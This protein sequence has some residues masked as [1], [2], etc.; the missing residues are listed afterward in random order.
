MTQQYVLRINYKWNDPADP[1][2][3]YLCPGNKRAQGGS[4]PKYEHTYVFVNDY[5]AVKEQQAEYVPEEKAGGLSTLSQISRFLLMFQTSLAFYSA[6]RQ[7][8]ENVLFSPFLL[9]ITLPS[10][11]WLLP[12]SYLSYKCG[13][14]STR[15]ISLQNLHWLQYPQL[16]QSPQ[17]AAT[18]LPILQRPLLNTG[19]CKYSKIRVL[20][21]DA[22]ILIPMVKYGLQQARQRSLL[23][24]WNNYRNIGMSTRD[25]IC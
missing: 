15:R 19:G 25:V 14:R 21:W 11:I 22:Q 17:P 18:H 5:S 3:C 16:L 4:N 24:S 13:P 1:F 10:L 23:S 2:K 20:Q 7:W 8:L 9:S 12:R 6:Q